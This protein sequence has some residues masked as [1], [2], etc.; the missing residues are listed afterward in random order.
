MTLAAAT[1]SSAECAFPSL[2]STNR[3]LKKGTRR[4]G[5]PVGCGTSRKETA[6]HDGH[7]E[8]PGRDVPLHVRR[9]AGS[10][11]RSVARDRGGDRLGGDPRAD[12][13]LLQPV[14]TAVDPAGAAA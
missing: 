5:G 14:G 4:A 9:P 10:R 1:I 13:P 11:R 7:L 2:K 6:T 12:G 8:H 3:L